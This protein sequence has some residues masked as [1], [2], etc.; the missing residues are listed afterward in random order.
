MFCIFGY[1]SSI[2]TTKIRRCE[3]VRVL[4]H[5][6][7]TMYV[8]FFIFYK[9]YFFN[10]NFLKIFCDYCLDIYIQYLYVTTYTLMAHH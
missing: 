7:I 10:F 3:N 8:D 2:L 6:E 9:Y 4:C 1:V 5:L